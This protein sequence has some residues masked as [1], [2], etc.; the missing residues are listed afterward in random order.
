M[1]LVLNTNPY[2]LYFIQQDSR[3]RNLGR[4]TSKPKKNTVASLLA[5]SR[6]LGIKPSAGLEVSPLNH[7]VS[8]LKSNILGTQ[9]S[10]PQSQQLP[11]T[12]RGMYKLGIIKWLFCCFHLWSLH[13]LH[14]GFV[15]GRKLKST[16]VG[17]SSCL[18]IMFHNGLWVCS[19]IIRGRHVKLTPLIKEHFGLMRLLNIWKYLKHCHCSRWSKFHFLG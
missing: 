14:V 5:Q 17:W 9:Q 1:K 10:P 15:D 3:P 13:G 2:F 16:K 6:A 19:E 8:L 12:N 4:G 11:A 18:C 7:Q